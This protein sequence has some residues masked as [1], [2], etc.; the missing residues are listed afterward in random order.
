MLHPSG[1]KFLHEH[2][3]N[4]RLHLIDD[5][6]HVLQLDQPKKATIHILDF[7]NEQHHFKHHSE[8]SRS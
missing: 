4:A 8:T 3:S 2:I 5:C 6:N 7:L 1:G